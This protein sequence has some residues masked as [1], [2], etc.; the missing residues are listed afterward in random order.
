M[1]KIPHRLKQAVAQVVHLPLMG[2]LMKL[3]IRLVVPKQ[4]VGA[5]VVVIN[6]QGCVLLL[7]HVFHPATPWD[8]PGGWLN[9]NEDPAAGALRELWEET[10]ITAELGPVV[11]LRYEDFP[12]HL[13]IAF[14]AFANPQSMRLSSEILDA[15]WFSPD[16]LPEEMTPFTR[17]A[18]ETAVK[19]YHAQ[20]LNKTSPLYKTRVGEGE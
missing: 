11:R 8:I 1:K 14:M 4:R 5:G 18:I 3:G 9:R 10:G 6:D 16:D 17:F 13:G 15:R 2:S 12:P 7:H 20:F 19:I